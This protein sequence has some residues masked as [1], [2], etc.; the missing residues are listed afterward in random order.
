MSK[1]KNE[2]VPGLIIKR[3]KRQYIKYVGSGAEESLWGP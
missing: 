2:Q 3:G 1:N